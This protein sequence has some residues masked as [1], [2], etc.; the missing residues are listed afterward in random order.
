MQ[1]GLLSGFNPSDA[2]MPPAQQGYRGLL[3]RLEQRD[4]V[5]A[6][7]NPYQ[8]TAFGSAFLPSAGISDVLG[9]A[10]DPNV[11][12]GTLPSF[13]QN[14]DQGNYIDAGLQTLGASGDVMLA[15]APFAPF[16]LAPAVGAKLISQFGKSVRGAS[17]VSD[18]VKPLTKDEIDPLGY[19]K[20]KG[21]LTRPLDETNIGYSKDI[22]LAP[23]KKLNIQDLQGSILYPLMGDQSATG[24]LIN[25][26]DDIAFKTP[27]K[28]EGGAKF[29]RGGSNQA[30]DT[31]WASDKGV[32]S[33][34]NREVKELSKKSDK[35]INMIYTAMGKH[36][37]DF[38]TFPS[39]VLAEQIPTA[40]ILKKDKKSFDS[41]MKKQILVKKKG[42]DTEEH[43]AVKDW[44]GVDSPKLREFLD[45][46]KPSIRKKF[47]KIMDQAQFQRAGFPSVGKARYAVT[48]DALK[49]KGSGD[50]GLVIARPNLEKNPTNNPLVP[51]GTYPSQMYGDYIGGL[52]NTVPRS[53]LFRDY[54]NLPEVLNLKNSAKQD[55]GFTRVIP[56]QE[57]DQQLVDT[58]MNYSLL[59]K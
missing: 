11:V 51:H 43:P 16:L 22:D 57:V 21:L 39:G 12:G 18:K 41:L 42:K 45:K 37:V 47:V 35:P 15:S 33:R 46:A 25:S 3:S 1:Q 23:E 44:V 20:T 30:E 8:A 27:V 29:M 7:I 13:T 59:N 10:P 9:F 52:D 58:I 48:D 54:F 38:S 31:V 32:I 28:L 14:M 50:T 19:G 5:G 24:L 55:Y 34:I 53:L 40:K 56:T 36:G 17:K 26:I 4:K 49:A 6:G 2:L